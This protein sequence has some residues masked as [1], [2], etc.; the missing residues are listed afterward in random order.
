[1]TR[2]SC[3]YS[4][5]LALT[6]NVY[7]C[8]FRILLIVDSGERAEV[9]FQFIAMRKKWSEERAA[10]ICMIN[11]CRGTEGHL[12]HST[13]RLKETIIQRRIIVMGGT[14]MIIGGHSNHS[15]TVVQ[16][17]Q[18]VHNPFIDNEA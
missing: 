8:F 2:E 11:W 4:H 13:S 3:I 15:V 7:L 17:V 12:T 16:R 10:L 1:M 14:L 6:F 9:Q 18:R 5:T